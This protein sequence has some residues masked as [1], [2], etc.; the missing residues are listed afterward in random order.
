VKE[1][2]Q[3]DYAK[4]F[5]ASGMAALVFDYRNLGT[6][7]GEPRQHL[8]P[9]QQIEDYKNAISYAETRSEI[10]AERIGI[11]GISYSGGHVLVVGATDPGSSA[12]SPTSR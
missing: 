10:D 2:V 11:W 1:L 7:D 8:D 3:P 6:S 5:V 12:S 4:A 9:W